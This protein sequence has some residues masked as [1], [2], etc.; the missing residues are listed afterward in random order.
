VKETSGIGVQC[1]PESAGV[2]DGSV[3]IT[4]QDAAK[5]KDDDNAIKVSGQVTLPKSSDAKK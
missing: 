3:T 5:T 4:K 1:V 2:T